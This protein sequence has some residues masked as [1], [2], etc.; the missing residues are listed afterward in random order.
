MFK[1]IISIIID[2]ISPRYTHMLEESKDN[3]EREGSNIGS[4]SFGLNSPDGPGICKVKQITSCSMNDKI[5][6]QGLTNGGSVYNGRGLTQGNGLMNGLGFTNGW[7]DLPDIALYSSIHIGI[8]PMENI[9]DDKDMEGFHFKVDLI[10]GLSRSKNGPE[11]KP[12]NGRGWRAR[13]R[14]AMQER[15]QKKALIPIDE[16]DSGRVDGGSQES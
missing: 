8:Q 16:L 14:R 4:G 13:K 6:G 12:S 1:D 11:G 3:V 9:E 15:L 5:N 10:N 7:A 2:R